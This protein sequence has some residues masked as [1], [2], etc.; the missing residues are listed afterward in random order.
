MQS[1]PTNFASLLLSFDSGSVI[2]NIKNK[3]PEQ[4]SNLQAGKGKNEVEFG[5]M[6]DKPVKNR[7]KIIASAI[8]IV[9]ILRNKLFEC[10]AME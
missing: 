7:Y 9:E 5:L 2:P 4:Y 3:M 10:F 1:A 6:K 8:K